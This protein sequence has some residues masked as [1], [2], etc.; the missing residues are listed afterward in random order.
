MI[1]AQSML[2]LD[3]IYGTLDRRIMSENLKFKLYLN[4]QDPQLQREI[5]EAYGRKDDG[6]YKVE[7]ARLGR[8]GKR[9][10]LLNPGNAIRLK[11]YRIFNGRKEK[12]W[13]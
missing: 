6:S 13:G 3:K 12:T 8:L 11:K 9:L 1:L 2:Q 5:A 10:V 7:P 4:V